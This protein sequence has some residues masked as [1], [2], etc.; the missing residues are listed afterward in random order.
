MSVHTKEENTLSTIFC[1][2]QQTTATWCDATF[3]CVVMCV[4]VCVAVRV[5]VCVAVRVA[6]CVALSVYVPQHSTNRVY[7]TR[8]EQLC[9]S[10]L[11][12]VLQCV[13]VCCSVMQCDAVCG[14]VLQT[15]AVCCTMCCNVLQYVLQRVAV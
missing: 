12:I 13:A 10:V 8:V 14:S 2:S 3:R 5:A 9:C 15:V 6:V 7:T 11:H 1:N 4:A